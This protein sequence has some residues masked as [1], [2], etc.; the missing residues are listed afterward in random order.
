VIYRHAFGFRLGVSDVQFD[1]ARGSLL[2]FTLLLWGFGALACQRH[3]VLTWFIVLSASRRG[4]FF[5]SHGGSCER[6][7]SL[8]S[9]D[10]RPDNS[11]HEKERRTDGASETQPILWST[12]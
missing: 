6:R 3:H 4:S 1:L 7:L 2:P 10:R 8:S 12:S 11:H 5:H 9:G